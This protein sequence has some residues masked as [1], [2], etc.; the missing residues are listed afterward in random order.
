MINFT[1]RLCLALTVLWASS[2]NAATLDATTMGSCVGQTVC[3]MGNE[4]VT[5]TGAPGSRLVATSYRGLT[6]LGIGSAARTEPEIQGAVYGHPGDVLTFDFFNAVTIDVLKIAHLFNPDAFGPRGDPIEHAVITAMDVNSKRQTLTLTSFS[7]VID[8]F[9]LTGDPNAIA[10]RDSA[11]NGSFTLSNLFGDLGLIKS[12]SFSGI[13]VTNP[14][15]PKNDS[16]DYA[17]SL[18]QTTESLSPPPPSVPLP[19]SILL[20]IGGLGALCAAGRFRKG[21]GRNPI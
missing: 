12:L 8:G 2:A 6:G 4:T 11:L 17:I 1:N 7:D 16:S 20:L 10:I 21:K 3:T 9:S 19:G 14:N 15:S 18:V 13:A 5:V